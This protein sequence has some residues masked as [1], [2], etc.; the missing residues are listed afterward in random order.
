MNFR[1]MRT[2][3]GAGARFDLV[4]DSS[5]RQN[6]VPVWIA[7]SRKQCAYRSGDA[8]ALCC[9]V[10]AVSIP[11]TALA[12]QQPI[13]P[14]SASKQSDAGSSGAFQDQLREAIQQGTTSP[15]KSGDARAAGQS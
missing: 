10:T 7:A 15:G 5:Q 1:P 8:N 14:D 11:S 6:F 13:R 4:T 12:P 2:E 3:C 9:P